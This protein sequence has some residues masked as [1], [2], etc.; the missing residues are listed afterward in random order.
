MKSFKD[1]MNS[2]ANLDDLKVVPL[3]AGDYELEITKIDDAA[4]TKFE[5]GDIPEGT[6]YVAIYLKA[7]RAIDVDEEE[8]DQCGDWQEKFLSIDLISQGDVTKLVDVAND[9][10]LV[11]DAG[12][13][14]NDYIADGQIDWDSMFKDLTGKHG[15][16]TIVQYVAKSTGNTG[17]RVK[18]TT[19][20]D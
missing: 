16:G 18:T 20:L 5:R 10:G 3:P 12:L 9:R 1:T 4:V 11:Y 8:L 7:V 13:D 14:P 2:A 15:Q 19:A 6:E 17:F